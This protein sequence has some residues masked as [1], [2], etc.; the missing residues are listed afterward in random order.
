MSQANVASTDK[1]YTVEEYL[2][3]ERAAEEKHEYVDGRIIAVES[4]LTMLIV[5]T[6]ERNIS[7]G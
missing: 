4:E 6:N 7:S 3:F 1:L 5:E 2:A